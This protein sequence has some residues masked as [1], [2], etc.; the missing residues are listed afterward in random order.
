[1]S[2]PRELLAAASGSMGVLYSGGVPG[3]GDGARQR[4]IFQGVIGGS[5]GPCL[6]GMSACGTAG[7]GERSSCTY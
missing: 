7:G 6:T 1:M 2:H 4:V 5:G 3:G